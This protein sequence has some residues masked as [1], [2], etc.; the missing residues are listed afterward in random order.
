MNEPAILNLA[1]LPA[2][3][4][5][6]QTAQLLGFLEHDIQVLMRARLLKPLG[7]PAPNGHKFF[8][9]AEILQLAQDRSWL[10]RATKAVS[11]RWQERNRHLI[12]GVRGNFHGNEE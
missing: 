12:Q 1:R 2:R 11:A 7:N 8:A 4:D 10:D 9:S 5:V 3:L 6:G